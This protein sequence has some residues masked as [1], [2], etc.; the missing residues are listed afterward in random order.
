MPPTAG[1]PISTDTA[2]GDLKYVVLEVHYDNYDNQPFT[3]NDGFRLWY[4][5][6]L[7]EH[8]VGILF[9]GNGGDGDGEIPNGQ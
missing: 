3:S 2:A 4:T 9:V 1:L 8:D 5:S 6:N 7:R